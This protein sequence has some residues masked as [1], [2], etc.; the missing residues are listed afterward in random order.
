VFLPPRRSTELPGSV[1]AI[2]GYGKL[3]AAEHQRRD[4]AT[5]KSF[6]CAY[7]NDVIS[8]FVSRRGAA[9]EARAAA[10]EK[11]NTANSRSNGKPGEFVGS[12]R[13]KAPRERLLF[14][15]QDVYGP[16][17]RRMEPLE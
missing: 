13:R 4:I 5:V 15:G 3:S 8:G 2:E 1:R 12:L 17:R 11:W 6:D 16:M 10:F 9:L 7:K 14:D